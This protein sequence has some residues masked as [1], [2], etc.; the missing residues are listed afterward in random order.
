MK[1]ITILTTVLLVLLATS[2]QADLLGLWHLDGDAFDSGVHNYLSVPHGSPLYTSD[3]NLGSAM[4][5]DGSD[6]YIRTST[7]VDDSITNKITVEVWIRYAEVDDQQNGGIVSSALTFLTGTGYNLFVWGGNLYW[8][9]GVG[10]VGD[11]GRVYYTLPESADGEWH[12][13]AGTWDGT[14]TKLYFDGVLVASKALAGTYVDP[15]RHNLIGKINTPTDYDPDRNLHYF[16]GDIDEV[17]IWNQALTAADLSNGSINLKSLDPYSDYNPVGTSHTVIATLLVAAASVPVEFDVNGANDGQVVTVYTNSSGVAEFTYTGEYSGMDTIYASSGSTTYT[18][19]KYWFENY[20]TGGATIKNTSGKKTLWTLAGIVGDPEGPGI[21]GNFQ[22]VDH[23]KKN[24]YHLSGFE[25][26]YL[27]F[28]GDPATS[29]DATHNTA[30][31]GGYDD[32]MNAYIYVYIRDL[33]EPGN[34]VDQI[35]VEIYDSVYDGSVIGD[36]VNYDYEL[37]ST[38]NYQVHDIP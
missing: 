19:Y 6:D 2:A 34:G 4:I 36:I 29:P 30:W 12:H 38:G 16:K 25:F 15:I 7:T 26:S 35:A 11:Y 33:N 28:Y 13:V 18:V 14:T 10:V 31:F 20:V 23:V 24:T 22:I 5:F 8:D 9:I 27:D 17:R 32:M 37:I 3:G 1:K 21:C